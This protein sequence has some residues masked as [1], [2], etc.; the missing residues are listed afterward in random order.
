MAFRRVSTTSFSK[1]VFAHIAKQTGR[2]GVWVK[3]WARRVFVVLQRSPIYSSLHADPGAYSDISSLA[4]T[5]LDLLDVF[6]LLSLID[7]FRTCFATRNPIHTG[8]DAGR[9]RTKRRYEYPNSFRPTI[10]IRR[11]V[12]VNVKPPKKLSGRVGVHRDLTYKAD[13][14]GLWRFDRVETTSKYQRKPQ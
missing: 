2:L 10:S 12:N 5:F 8:P 11:I 7:F 9:F 14:K 13:G 6:L 4:V 3:Y 1:R